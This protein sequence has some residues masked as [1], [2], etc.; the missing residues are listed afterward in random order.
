[1]KNGQTSFNGAVYDASKQ[2]QK[3]IKQSQSTNISQ[4]KHSQ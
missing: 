1:M 2:K 4:K 3:M